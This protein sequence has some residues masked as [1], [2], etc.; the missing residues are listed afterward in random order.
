MKRNEEMLYLESDPKMFEGRFARCRRL[1]HFLALEQR[2]LARIA[3][4]QPADL[5]FQKVV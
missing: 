4:R 2:V 3:D 1:L 5:G